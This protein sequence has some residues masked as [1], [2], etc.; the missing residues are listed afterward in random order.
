MFI[1]LDG[2]IQA[3]GGPTEDPTGSFPH[4]GWM[5]PVADEQV[6]AAIGVFFSRPYDLLLGRRTYDIFAAY[7][8]YADGEGAA[9]GEAFTAANKYVL[10]RGEQPLPWANSHRMRS[11]EDVAALKQEDGPD[12]LIQGSSMIYPALLTAG[13]LDR[14]VIYTF[15]IVL[16][17]G[18]RLFGQG[19]PP[20]TLRLVDH[21]I[22]S[23]G[24]VIATYEPAGSVET[25][26]FGQIASAREDERQAKMKDGT[27]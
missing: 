2:V 18:K 23:G 19:T 17:T 27:W 6:G 20:R 15:P 9:M 13:L 10:T 24:T 12:L 4:G 3:P 25:G 14:L 7:W 22:S 11:V 21:R 5:F 1:S 8:P 16:G 26:S